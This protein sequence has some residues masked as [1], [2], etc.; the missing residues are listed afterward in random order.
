MKALHAT[1]AVN[2]D[3][4]IRHGILASKAK[5]NRKTC[6]VT[7]LTRREWACAHVRNRHGEGAVAL[8]EV[9][10]PR[11]WL[12]KGG[13]HHMKH[14]GGRDIP[15]ARIGQILIVTTTKIRSGK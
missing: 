11:G 2:V 3:S 7:N 13:R 6:W 10:V 1:L 12:R 5:G 8:I 9:S 15:P 14:T 4:I